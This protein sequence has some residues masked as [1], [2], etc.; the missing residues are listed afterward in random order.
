MILPEYLAIIPLEDGTKAD[1]ADRPTHVR[2]R[3]AC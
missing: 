2:A 3:Q 1:K